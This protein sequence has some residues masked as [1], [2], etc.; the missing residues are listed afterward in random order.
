M[1]FK[2]NCL[3]KKNFRKYYRKPVQ[4]IA[5][6]TETTL[7]NERAV[8]SIINELLAQQILFITALIITIIAPIAT[9]FDCLTT[10][11]AMLASHT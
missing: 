11:R 1:N 2:A 3:R 4:T 8:R 10:Y 7:I 9:F 6:I 5:E